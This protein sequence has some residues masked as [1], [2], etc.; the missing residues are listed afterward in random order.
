MSQTHYKLP[1]DTEVDKDILEW[2]NS[3]PR[4]KKGE[5]VRH[6]IRYYMAELGEGETIKF[7]QS[8]N[9]VKIKPTNKRDDNSDEVTKNREERKRKKPAILP[10]A[11]K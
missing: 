8:S 6:A 1:V 2:I 11:I 9:V 3:F 10:S 7:P 5:M 4:N